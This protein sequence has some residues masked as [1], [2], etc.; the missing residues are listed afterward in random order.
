MSLRF[1][2]THL[3]AVTDRLFLS[4]RKLYASVVELKKKD[5]VRFQRDKQV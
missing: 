4:S 5:G 1:S 3:S 2:E